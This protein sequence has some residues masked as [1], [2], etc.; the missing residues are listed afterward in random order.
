[1]LKF[2]LVLFCLFFSAVESQAQFIKK[3]ENPVTEG[4][5][6][7]PVAQSARWYYERALIYHLRDQDGRAT[8]ELYKALEKH[9]NYVEANFFLG[10]LFEN[11]NHWDDAISALERVVSSTSDHLPAKIHLAKAKTEK[12]N[13]FDSITILEKIA[14][15]LKLNA[16]YMDRLKL[17]L[18]DLQKRGSDSINVEAVRL[19]VRVRLKR[20]I[21]EAED[22]MQDS[23]ESYQAATL[24]RGLKDPLVYNDMAILYIE[25]DQPDQAIGIYEQLLS[26]RDGFAPSVLLQMGRIYTEQ[27]RYSNAINVLE[28][29]VSQLTSL[30]FSEAAGDF[31]TEELEQLKI[32]A[33]NPGKAKK[34]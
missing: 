23:P 34:K 6:S 21:E 31:S 28:R 14:E 12:G 24:A 13:Y 4:G 17:C 26:E 9:S 20:L 29:A 33:K 7:V 19:D 5:I 2:L 18:I 27:E 32:R 22:T 10:L 25:Q 3:A 15:T 11:R 8:I 1:M 16:I 30:G